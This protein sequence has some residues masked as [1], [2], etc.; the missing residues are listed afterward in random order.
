MGNSRDI[1]ILIC[2][3]SP[4]ILLPYLYK[5]S[6]P[7]FAFFD[8][9]AIILWHKGFELLLCISRISGEFL[10]N[11]IMK[12]VLPKLFDY[13][14]NRI[15]FHENYKESHDRDYELK[16]SPEMLFLRLLTDNLE[17][18]G[19]NLALREEDIVKI[20]EFVEKCNRL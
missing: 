9:N 1:P 16:S 11:T 4:D 12:K 10:R 13:L 19:K 2:L 15:A 3:F 7:L 18:F 8:R 5:L 20:N 6:K 14:E 17:E